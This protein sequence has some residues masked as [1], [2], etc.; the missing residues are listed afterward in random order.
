MMPRLTE[1]Y[2]ARVLRAYRGEGLQARV[3][4]RPDGTTV[5]EP[6]GKT[7]SEAEIDKQRPGREIEL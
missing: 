1:A 2:I 5:F 7:N 4:R 3:V 6:I